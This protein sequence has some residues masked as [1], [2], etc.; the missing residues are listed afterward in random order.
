MR[1]NRFLDRKVLEFSIQDKRVDLQDVFSTEPLRQRTEFY[2]HPEHQR[3]LGEV[4]LGDEPIA[5]LKFPHLLPFQWQAFEVPIHVGLVL[6][7]FVNAQNL[8]L[9][10]VFSIS[11]VPIADI[12]LSHK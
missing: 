10:G 12:F 8:L 4:G 11:G 1:L 9:V 5:K 3:I 2:A 7:R 6:F